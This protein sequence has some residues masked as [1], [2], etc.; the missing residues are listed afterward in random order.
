MNVSDVVS[1]TGPTD[2]FDES[3]RETSPCEDDVNRGL[4]DGPVEG[5]TG[6][7][8]E[9][10]ESEGVLICDEYHREGACDILC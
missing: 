1:A 8:V 6:V 10:V 7:H 2:T 5:R 4:A 3:A 9:R